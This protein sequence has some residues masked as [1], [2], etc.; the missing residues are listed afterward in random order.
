MKRG[1][2]DLSC[3]RL[4]GRMVAALAMCWLVSDGLGTDQTTAL[5][6]ESV[7]VITR[8][9]PVK[10]GPAA[11]THA[12]GLRHVRSS[13][14]VAAWFA[15]D[16]TCIRSLSVDGGRTWSAPMPGEPLVSTVPPE[17]LLASDTREGKTFSVRSASRMPGRQPAF[18][19]APLVVAVQEG[20]QHQDIGFVSSPLDAVVRSAAVASGTDE[21]VVAYITDDARCNAVRLTL[22]GVTRASTTWRRLA[23]LPQGTG[24]AGIVA[25]IHDDVLIAGGGTNFPDAPPWA[26]GKRV[27]YDELFVLAPGAEAWRPVGRLPE[28]RGYAAVA[29]L[30]AGVLVAGGENPEGLRDDA[31]LLR[32]TGREAETTALP[33]L[34]QSVTQAAAVE[35]AGRVYL[36]GGAGGT[37][38]RE[39]LHHFLVYDPANA[40]AGW[41]ELPPWPG[42]TRTLAVMTA[43]DG[44]IYLV[45]G[46]YLGVDAA[47]KTATEYLRDA[48]RYRVETGEWERLPDLPWS[49]TAAPVVAMARG[50]LVL[51]G[52]DGTQVG[53]LPREA[54]LPDD[55][56]HFDV[57]KRTWEL[58]PEAW[59]EPVVTS[60]ALRWQDGWVIPSGEPRGGVRTPHV[61]HWQPDERPE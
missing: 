20:G 25:G 16:G 19:S 22:P 17:G 33:R 53:K 13:T 46:L 50:F 57:V 26:G 1:E 14:Y 45:S 4:P 52:V 58:W 48:Y 15:P 35:W 56:L 49:V 24:V 30:A 10:L 32:W 47:G 21:I 11:A 18:P 3:C 23:D 59:P 54:P 6:E 5:S 42:P 7:Q 34:P 44:W 31:F 28:P 60:P 38:P 36:A 43:V 9:N 12:I 37:T 2:N 29:S 61:W 27:T 51:G 8:M 41:V 39:S 40:S 55:I